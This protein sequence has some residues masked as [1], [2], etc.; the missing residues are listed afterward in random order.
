[1]HCTLPAN[2]GE[3]IKPRRRLSFI[4]RRGPK[5][6]CAAD[7]TSTAFLA[8]PRPCHMRGP[9]I[10]H[11]LPFL[12]VPPSHA[13][14]PPTGLLTYLSSCSTA[15]QERGRACSFRYHAQVFAVLYTCCIAS[16]L[17]LICLLG[18]LSARRDP[19][20]GLYRD[21]T[22]YPSVSYWLG[23]SYWIWQVSVVV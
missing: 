22:Q 3:S 1:M 14:Q 20:S 17:D 9:L 15:Y 4:R 18:L 6:T 8:M 12:P 21:A 7:A 2:C 23:Q 16:R 19:V 11:H 13:G 5:R 10:Y